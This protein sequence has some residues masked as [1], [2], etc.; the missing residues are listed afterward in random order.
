M[1]KALLSPATQS[2]RALG[3]I[4]GHRG[5]V[6][7]PPRRAGYR[8]NYET[9]KTMNSEWKAFLLSNSAEIEDTGGV[10]FPDAPITADCALCDLSHL[11]L[12]AVSG[13]DAQEFLQGQ[14]TNDLRELSDTHSQ[15]SSHCSP[16]GRMLASFRVFRVDGIFFLQ[17]PRTK[18]DA[19]FK[20]LQ[21]FVLRSE[22]KLTDASDDFATVGI[23]GDCA[24]GLLG[25][26]FQGLPE[27]DHDMIRQ[28]NLVLIRVPGAI[29]RFQIVGP[30]A[31]MEPVWTALSIEATPVNRNHWTLL[32]IRAGV[33]N[34]YPETSD[35]FVPQMVNMQLI[36]GVSFTKGC[37]TGQEVVARMQYLGK[38]KRRMYLGEVTADS[39]PTPGD[40]LHSPESSSEQAAGRI[41]DVCALGDGRYELLA[42]VEIAAAER[43][44]VCL[45][46]SGPP[47]KLDEPPYGFPAES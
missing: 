39:P 25:H 2:L 16:K 41:V 35:A 15:L 47:L 22:V 20:R 8:F 14:L 18:L 29:P 23:S 7:A 12:I 27:R 38:L 46:K 31:A 43:G 40:E 30:A 9:P 24:T 42:V 32:D 6:R 1:L 13:T 10:R 28:G 36:D 3:M 37:Y 21:M 4:Q 44:D 5:R 26:L 45:G 19:S 11:G 33:P 34:V 17:L